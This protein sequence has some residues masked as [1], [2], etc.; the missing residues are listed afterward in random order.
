MTGLSK[1]EQV[2]LLKKQSI[3]FLNELDQ[4]IKAEAAQYTIRH[5]KDDLYELIDVAKNK[6]IKLD[7]RKEIDKWLNRRNL[8]AYVWDKNK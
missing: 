1:I 3:V 7:S 8:T 6:L 2:I 5:Y 4:T